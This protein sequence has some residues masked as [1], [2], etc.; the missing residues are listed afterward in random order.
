MPAMTTHIIPLGDGW[1]V[2]KAGRR[3]RSV[4]PTQK[5]AIEAARKVAFRSS[6]G[7]IVVH[8][9]NGSMRLKDIWGLPPVQPS[10][11]KS[12]LGTKAIERAVSAVIRERLGRE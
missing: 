9:R 10:A 2:R 12:D 8:S 7:Q 4:Y 5:Q 6:A 3:A 11:R 1:A